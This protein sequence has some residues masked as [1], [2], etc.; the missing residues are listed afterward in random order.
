MLIFTNGGEPEVYLSSADFMPRNFDTRVETIFPV[1]DPELRTQ[2][3]DYFDIQ[4]SDNTKARLLDRNLTNGYRVAKKG[5]KKVRA[6]FAIE[7]YLRGTT[8]S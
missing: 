2:L 4:W 7:D 8:E 5:G 3:I 1:Y 6:Q